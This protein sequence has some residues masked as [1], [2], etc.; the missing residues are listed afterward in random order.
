MAPGGKKG[1]AVGA[2]SPAHYLSK[3][4]GGGGGWGVSHTRTGPGRPPVRQTWPPATT[5][6][7]GWKP[8]CSQGEGDVE[9]GLHPR[10]LHSQVQ[11]GRKCRYRPSGPGATFCRQAASSSLAAGM[12]RARGGGRGGRCPSPHVTAWGSPPRARPRAHAPRPRSPRCGLQHYV[13]SA[14]TAPSALF[15]PCLGPV[16]PRILCPARCPQRSAARNDAG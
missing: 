5:P 10:G 3:P 15:G 13:P 11:H 16:Q 9:F 1:G 4:G 12:T 2:M 7:T 8:P 6:R 14:Q